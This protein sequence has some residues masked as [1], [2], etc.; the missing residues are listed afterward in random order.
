[1]AQ[2]IQQVSLWFHWLD[3]IGI[4]YISEVDYKDEFNNMCPTAIVRHMQEASGWLAKRRKW[5]N[6]GFIFGPGSRPTQPLGC[7][8]QQ[9]LAASAGHSQGLGHRVQVMGVAAGGRGPAPFAG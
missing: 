9:A 4:R 7:L 6:G 8:L 5:R 1:M 3:T 2:S